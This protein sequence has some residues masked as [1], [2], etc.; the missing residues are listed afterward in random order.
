MVRLR[1]RATGRDLPTYEEADRARE[2]EAAAR[3]AAEARTAELEARVLALE[4]AL[5]VRTRQHPEQRGQRGQRGQ[6]TTSSWPAY[7]GCTLIMVTS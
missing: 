7:A 4:K 3:R 1:D 6:L 5:A 2:E